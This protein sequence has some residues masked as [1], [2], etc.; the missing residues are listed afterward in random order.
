[1]NLCLSVSETA[2]LLGISK[3]SVYQLV[4]EG[5]LPH[6]RVGRRLLIPAEQL[7]MWIAASSDANPRTAEEN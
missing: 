3:A 5:T 7:E 1:M 6:I 2:Q 4:R